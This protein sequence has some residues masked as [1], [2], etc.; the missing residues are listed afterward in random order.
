MSTGESPSMDN[1]TQQLQ[2]LLA[3]LDQTDNPQQLKEQIITLAY[4]RLRLLARKML[5][6]YDRHKLDEETDG[7][8]AE[9]YVRIDRALDDLKPETVRQFLALAALQIRRQLLDKLRQIHGRGVE[10]KPKQVA[11][12]Q[13]QQDSQSGVIEPSESSG[14]APA[15]TSLDV[16]AAMDQLDERERECLVLQN[17]YN[18]THAEIAQLQGVSTKT[19]QRACNSAYLKLQELLQGYRDT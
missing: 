14:P 11:F 1:T 9:A 7:V 13:L 8:I 19:V 4:S 10:R 15:W 5:A 16:L 3:Q 12:G 2:S 6:G 18:F 17:W